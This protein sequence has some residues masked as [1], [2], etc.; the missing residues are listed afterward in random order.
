MILPAWTKLNRLCP[1]DWYLSFSLP[2]TKHSYGIYLNLTCIIHAELNS[3]MYYSDRMHCSLQK[4]VNSF[5]A[6]I[7]PPTLN[8]PPCDLG[9]ASPKWKELVLFPL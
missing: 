2:P 1:L 5:S 4:I 7:C 3:A 8:T 6:Y 9:T